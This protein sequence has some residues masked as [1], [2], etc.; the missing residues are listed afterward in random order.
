MPLC[1]IFHLLIVFLTGRYLDGNL[2]ISAFT[3][4]THSTG[5]MQGGKLAGK[6]VGLQRGPA[7]DNPIRKHYQAGCMSEDKSLTTKEEVDNKEERRETDSK[8]AEVNDCSR[9]APCKRVNYLYLTLSREKFTCTSKGTHEP[10]ANPNACYKG[11]VS[12]S[13]DRTIKF[14]KIQQRMLLLFYHTQGGKRKKQGN[15]NKT[16]KQQRRNP[17]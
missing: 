11:S 13:G 12:L 15:K 6:V 17:P 2:Q 10:M 7:V 8:Q 9:A 5:P 3:R 14:I 1:F 4:K 16:K